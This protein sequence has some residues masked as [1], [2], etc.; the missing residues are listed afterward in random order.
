MAVHRKYL[1]I[2]T[3]IITQYKK[4]YALPSPQ[5]IKTSGR[6]N[7]HNHLHQPNPAKRQ[8]PKAFLPFRCKLPELL[9]CYAYILLKKAVKIGGIFKPNLV[10]YFLDA[11]LISEEQP[12]RF[13]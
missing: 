10:A 3:K 13:Q 1:T 6:K 5:I 7:Q 9:W 11:K 4:I 2:A 12:P 8:R